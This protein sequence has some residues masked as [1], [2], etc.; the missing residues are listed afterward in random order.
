[1]SIKILFEI[2]KKL[3]QFGQIQLIHQINHVSSV[4]RIANYALTKMNVLN[5]KLNI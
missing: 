1:M 3:P 5:A 2:K 4:F